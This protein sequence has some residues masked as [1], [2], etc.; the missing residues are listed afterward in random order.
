MFMRDVGVGS[1]M[2]PDDGG[3]E[4]YFAAE[5]PVV[6]AVVVFDS[7]VLIG[8]RNDGKPPWTFIAGEQEPGER[9]EDTAIREVKEEAGLRVQVGH[10]IGERIHPKTGRRMIYLTAHP[11]HG[12]DAFVGDSDELAEVRWA[13]LSEAD[14]LLP[15]MYEPVRE[16]LGR[17]LAEGESLE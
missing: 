4:D 5:Q 11:T 8:R 13:D 12:A 9:P 7:R 16:H 14:E 1:R 2:M 17:E 6:A 10:V 3:P 15:G